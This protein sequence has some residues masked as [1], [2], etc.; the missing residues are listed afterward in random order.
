MTMP[1]KVDEQVEDYSNPYSNNDIKATGQLGYAPNPVERTDVGSAGETLKQTTGDG[2]AGKVMASLDNTVRQNAQK[3][4]TV[5]DLIRM[6]GELDSKNRQADADYQRRLAGWTKYHGAVD[7]GNAIADLFTA[8]RGAKTAKYRKPTGHDGVVE[9]E[10]ARILRQQRADN[11]QL[12]TN[13]LNALKYGDAE[14]KNRY[15]NAYRQGLTDA[16]AQRANANDRN[17]DSQIGRREAQNENDARKVEIAQQNANTQSSSVANQ[18]RN[19]DAKTGIDQQNA[20]TRRLAAESV[21]TQEKEYIGS[22]GNPVGTVKTTTTK[23]ANG[24][25]KQVSGFGGGKSDKKQIKGFNGR[26]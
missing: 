8:S 19:R 21:Q 26:K 14:E 11:Q 25:K 22:D 12:Y 10:F 3:M 5:S 6:N 18:N 13:A 4:N 24:N 16:A 23:T 9:N 7:L 2:D 1:R 20:D 17:V 15:L